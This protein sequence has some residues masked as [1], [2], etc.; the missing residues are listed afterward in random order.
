MGVGGVVA[1]FLALALDGGEWSASRP[2]RFTPTGRA[3]GTRCMGA[4]VGPRV[5]VAGIEPRFLG[6][7]D[8]SLAAIPIEPC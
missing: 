8:G 7:P 1:P 3:S 2:C 5:C 6:R 4:W